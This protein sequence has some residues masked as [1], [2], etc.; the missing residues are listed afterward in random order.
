MSMNRRDLLLYISS[1]PAT[2]VLSGCG[3]FWRGTISVAIMSTAET[4]HTIELI[5]SQDNETVYSETYELDPDGEIYEED[6][7]DGG[8]YEVTAIVD[9]EGRYA[10]RL[11][12]ERCEEQLLTVNQI[13]GGEIEFDNRVC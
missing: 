7:I 8:Q 10:Y 4:S 11:K 2:A 6:L 12:M 13:V 3:R 1:V 9:N 5:F